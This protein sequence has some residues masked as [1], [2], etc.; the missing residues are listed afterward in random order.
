[1]I[2]ISFKT[3]YKTSK[4]PYEEIYL[5]DVIE[6]AGEKYKV[7]LRLHGIALKPEGKPAFPMLKVDKII[8]HNQPK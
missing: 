3:R 7:V 5:G 2:Q 8:Y 6:R 4:A 1:M